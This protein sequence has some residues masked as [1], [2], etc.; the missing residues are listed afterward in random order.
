MRAVAVYN[1]DQTI[2][3]NYLLITIPPL[4]QWNVVSRK[5]YHY[6]LRYNMNSDHFKVHIDKYYLMGKGYGL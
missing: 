4:S 6:H 2:P 3:F 1:I 5:W